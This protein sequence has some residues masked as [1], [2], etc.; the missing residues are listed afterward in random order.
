MP[1]SGVLPIN[2]TISAG[3]KQRLEQLRVEYDASSPKDPAGVMSVSWGFLIPDS[4]RRSEGVVIG[5]YPQSI[6]ADV[7]HGIQEVSGIKL[8]F[9]TTAEYHGKFEGKVLDFAVERGFF[10]KTP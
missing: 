5:I 3:A 1:A 2:F 8:V 6:L 9:F 10:L 4:G 7:A